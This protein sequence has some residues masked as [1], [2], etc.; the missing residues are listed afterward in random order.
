[1]FVLLVCAPKLVNFAMGSSSGGPQRVNVVGEGNHADGGVT[2][3]GGD[4][5]GIRGGINPFKKGVE[6]QSPLEGGEGAA[7]SKAAGEGDGA[8]LDVPCDDG[9]KT[10]GVEVHESWCRLINPPYTSPKNTQ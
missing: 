1:M 3:R 6:K 8:S 7:L 10:A 2:V 4:D 9:A 5:V